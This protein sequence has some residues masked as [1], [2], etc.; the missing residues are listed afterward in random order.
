MDIPIHSPHSQSLQG[1]GPLRREQV[2]T[3]RVTISATKRSRH[4]CG[5]LQGSIRFLSF[6]SCP[7][8]NLEIAEFLHVTPSLLKTSHE[9]FKCFTCTS[10]LRSEIPDPHVTP[11]STKHWKH[12]TTYGISSRTTDITSKVLREQLNPSVSQFPNCNLTSLS[13]PRA[14]SPQHTLPS[15]RFPSAHVTCKHHLHLQTS[16]DLVPVC[17]YPILSHFNAEWGTSDSWGMLC[18]VHCLLPWHKKF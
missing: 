12:M 2:A 16:T 13:S 9:C 10:R 15:H 7:K 11:E 5:K 3:Y 18:Q 14:C 6:P 4:L 17:F 1:L 8:W